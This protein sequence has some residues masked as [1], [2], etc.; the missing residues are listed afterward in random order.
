MD[1]RFNKFF[2]LL[3]KL[4]GGYSNHPVDKGGATNYGV[5]QNT[6]DAYRANKK[7]K[8]QSVKKST[9]EEAKKIYFEEYYSKINYIEDEFAHYLIFDLAVNS[10]VGAAKK[11]IAAVNNPHDPKEILSYRR[12]LFNTIVKNNTSQQVF[13]KGWLSRLRLI[14]K[15]FTQDSEQSADKK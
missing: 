15:E 12:N 9:L 7:L 11:C 13:L 2:L 10:G 14:E 1:D 8:T 6:Y 3:H 5:T 4:E